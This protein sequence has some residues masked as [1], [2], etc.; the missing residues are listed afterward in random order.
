M[1]TT[2]TGRPG[3]FVTE[4]LTPLST[5]PTV[6]SQAVAAFV[7][8]HNAGPVGPTRITSWSQWRTLYGGFGTGQ[9]YLPYA[10]YL[11]FAN[12]GAQAYVVRAVA[13]DAVAASVALNDLGTG[14]SDHTVPQPVLTLTA[15]A[16]GATGN[17][18]FIDIVS[19]IGSTG[20]FNLTVRNGGPSTPP[21]E[22]YTDVSLS[23]ADPRNLI[24][25]IGARDSGSQYLTAA[26]TGS[27]S[28]DYRYTPGDQSGTPLTGGLDGT[29]T[30]DLVGATQL[31]DA[32]DGVLDV[33]LPG[34][35]D[36]TVINPLVTWATAAT[37]RFLVV[38]AP[39]A[40]GTYADT[41]NAYKDLSPL[42]TSAGTPFTSS[43]YL[44]VYGPWLT[45]SDPSAQ[46]VGATRL[47]PPGAAML[48]LY[49]QADQ[50]SGTQQSA[51]GGSFPISGAVAAQVRFQNADL[52]SLNML[53]INVIRAV[54]GNSGVVPMGARTLAS[55]MPDRYI[56]IRRTLMYVT[57]LCVQATSFAVFRPNNADLWDQVT[58]VLS[59]EL[60]T[61]YQAGVL[62]GSTAS[63]A[64]QVICNSTN[65]TENSV[66]NGVVNVQVGVALNTPGEY[67][68]IQI[69][70]LAT[71]ATTS[72]NLSS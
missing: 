30:V 36:P 13:P 19:A 46:A 10:M 38:D 4:S 70:Q 57:H 56:S 51:A 8:A 59:D 25:M 40:A 68:L 31:L 48:G 64:F 37:N 67:I 17:S 35:S 29:A 7:G 62:K 18:L 49:A 34:V 27:G 6:P 9:D 2:I 45:A 11:F 66:A 55:G 14:G 58:S 28:W 50:N 71:G 60:T 69:G 32:V 3:V 16:P 5:T 20:R 63:Q 54:S 33:N 47:L 22:Q 52:D 61:L 53:G 21:V 44:A 23:P 1:S 12:G 15:T 26:Y 65:N 43:S 42:G 39:L 72:D 41:V 24:A